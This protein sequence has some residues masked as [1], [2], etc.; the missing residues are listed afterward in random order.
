MEY[1]FLSFSVNVKIMY[2]PW[3]LWTGFPGRNFIGLLCFAACI[4]AQ[5]NARAQ[6][7]AI[8]RISGHI[9]NKHG[10]ADLG[11]LLLTTKSFD[12]LSGTKKNCDTFQTSVQLIDALRPW[13]P[14]WFATA[15][16]GFYQNA[17]MLASGEIAYY[18]YLP[19]SSGSEVPGNKMQG[20]YKILKNYTPVD[21]IVSKVAV[22]DPHDF[23]INSFNERLLLTYLDTVLNV[24]LLTG[25]LGDTTVL[26]L[27]GA[28]EIWDSTG[29]CIFKWNP[30]AKMR[31][32]E[33]YP[34]YVQFNHLGPGANEFD[35]NHANSVSWA[36][37]GNI[38]YSFRNLGVGKI[39]RT[40]GE[41]MWRLGGLKP[42]IFLPDS[43]RYFG[44]HDFVQIATG[45]YQHMYSVFSNGDKDH[46]AAAYIY[47]IDENFKTARLVHKELADSVS[48]SSAAGNYTWFNDKQLICY[49]VLSS[50]SQE[51]PSRVTF[52]HIADAQNR[53]LAYYQIPTRTYVYRA[54][55][56]EQHKNRTNYL[57]NRPVIFSGGKTLM[58]KP[59][60]KGKITWYNISNEKCV[61]V[62]NGSFFK[63]AQ[64]G[65]FV[66]T[67]QIN[68]GFLVSDPIHFIF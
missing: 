65:V 6:L 44:Q 57:P 39:N 3:V 32:D 48:Y 8:P 16:K 62:G 2:S 63:P 41:I 1:S 5:Q 49:G 59:T 23:A 42:D 9:Y 34:S 11:A 7:N 55:P 21:S 35:W 61:E 12:L 22:L 53:L 64:S 25:N 4:L 51:T 29:K 45:P 15:P 19:D 40:N 58:T 28:I 46:I 56:L 68:S 26:C 31:V 14:L 66:V 18:E 43:M 50:F 54:Q 13:P 24:S 20:S 47:A 37:D 67:E 17:K 38:L 60:G 33:R 30:L 27:I 52:M 36:E 10:A